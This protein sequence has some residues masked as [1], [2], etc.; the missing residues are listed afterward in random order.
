MG[1]G[2][3]KR[4]EFD[5]SN[6]RAELNLAEFNLFQLR[7]STP[8]GGAT[9]RYELPVTDSARNCTIT[10][11]LTITG[12]D[13][14]GLPTE[15]D[16]DVFYAL[17]LMAFQDSEF[18]SRELQF[19]RYE[20]LELLGKDHSGANYE[21]IRLALRRLKGTTFD[22]EN[23]WDSEAGEWVD[24]SFG[25]IDNFKLIKGTRRKDQPDLRLSKCSLN[26]EFLSKVSLSFIRKF[27]YE[28]WVQL[29][30][31][32]AKPMYHLIGKR[33]GTNRTSVD[34]DLRTFACQ[35]L[36][37]ARNCAPTKIKERLKPAIEELVS[38]GY[39]DDLPDSERYVKIRRGEW[40][41]FF[42]RKKPRPEKEA[43]LDLAR[44]NPLAKELIVLGVQ[45]EV[46]RE[47]AGDPAYGEDYL[48]AKI[49]MFQWCQ[50]RDND[51]KSPGWLCDAIRHDWQPP[52]SFKPKAERE[53]ERERVVMMKA[54]RERE[55]RE[56]RAAEEQALKE[57]RI[58]EAE[59]W[60][61]INDYLDR[62]T[63]EAR[64]ALINDAI[65]ATQGF[66]RK[67][68]EQYRRNPASKKG[69]GFYEMAVRNHVLP[70]LA[71][72]S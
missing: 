62:L 2:T 63:S 25:L 45:P 36:G 11:S 5:P 26:E 24:V 7:Q 30:T 29:K 4:T 27:N 16:G 71:V 39:F 35:H 17:M 57:D 37:V 1:T 31:K 52:K 60:K 12:S 48:R 46:A 40:R 21:R 32:T 59:E 19:S 9:V 64:E 67:G 14:Y 72:T 41:I 69:L 18:K 34:F 66:V 47:M 54:K 44:E 51:Q 55:A 53:A 43:R 65:A 6:A 61:L 50:E 28:E 42:T 20:L 58:R 49:E 70:L 8:K 56:A 22:Y 68:A 23:W 15:S 38:I 33:L 3:L 13:A 10:R